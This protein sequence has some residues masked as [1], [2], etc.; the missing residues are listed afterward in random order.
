MF[1]VLRS[2]SS[3]SSERAPQRSHEPR[4]FEQSKI[5]WNGSKRQSQL[6]LELSILKKQ[7]HSGA[8]VDLYR[9]KCRALNDR[10][11][12][13]EHD[14]AK[15]KVVSTISRK[16]NWLNASSLTQTGDVE[17]KLSVAYEEVLKRDQLVETMKEQIEHLKKE[18]EN[19]VAAFQAGQRRN[20]EALTTAALLKQ[21]NIM[22]TQKS[23]EL[24]GHVS[25][26]HAEKK[27]MERHNEK[28]KQSVFNLENGITIENYKEENEM[29]IGTVNAMSQQVADLTSKLE[30][31]NQQILAQD[32]EIHRAF[33]KDLGSDVGGNPTEHLKNLVLHGHVHRAIGTSF[34][35]HPETRT[36]AQQALQKFLALA[37]KAE[38][39]PD[40]KEHHTLLHT[41]SMVRMIQKMGNK[42]H[43]GLG[44]ENQ[45]KE[46]DDDEKGVARENLEKLS[47]SIGCELS[48]NEDGCIEIISTE[49]DQSACYSG[50]E[51][52]DIIVKAKDEVL[53]SLEEFNAVV[54][55]A[56]VGHFLKMVIRRGESELTSSLM[57]G[58]VGKA[59]EEV[60]ALTQKVGDEEFFQKQTEPT[61]EVDKTPEVA[62]YD[63]FLGGSCN[64]TTWRS[65]IAVGEF[66]EADVSYYNPQ[67]DDWS[68]ALVAL[69]AHV[70]KNCLI[71]L[72]V[73]DKMTR[74]IASMLEAAEYISTGR[75]V[76]LAVQNVEL[77][78][79]F[80]GT[81][82]SEGEI[83]DLNRARSYLLDVALRHGVSYFTSPNCVKE[84]IA[85]VIQKTKVINFTN[86]DKVISRAPSRAQS[87]GPSRSASR[88]A[89]RGPS[90]S[91]SRAASRLEKASIEFRSVSRNGSKAALDDTG[92]N[93][94]N[95]LVVPGSLQISRDFE[96]P[97]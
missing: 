61:V 32:L 8:D 67:R 44:S 1:P 13:L 21:K 5:R 55:E 11:K 62:A 65:E 49:K 12:Q 51:V 59:F 6:M 68:P 74:A 72:F 76:V 94:G 80:F 41:S 96:S 25:R 52:G 83:K 89:S 35:A 64:P 46:D 38:L 73:I 82:V 81:E 95:L 15:R 3:S 37:E 16:Q 48:T 42:F 7:A 60:Q 69:E 54:E 79:E 47:P 31:A 91:A 28:L 4:G 34:H 66:K 78:T 70:K 23:E 85:S 26:I 14:T 88:A 58:A 27:A 18:H 53:S 33:S 17:S 24:R 9:R 93:A 40:D 19:S 63:V 75:H 30:K 45:E 36:I 86:E 92:G 71:L 90:R 39:N 77:G 10:V 84:A 29:M 56:G 2:T 97:I 87:R 50:L 20:V 57:I 22:L 43:A